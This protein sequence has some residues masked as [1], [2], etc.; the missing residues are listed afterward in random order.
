ML[1]NG[2][3]IFPA[4]LKSIRE[5]HRRVSFETYIYTAGEMAEQ[6]TRA[7]EEA[8]RR[9]VRVNLVIDAV[10]G[11]IPDAHVERLR[12]AGCRLATFNTPS[13]YSLEEIN[14]R[15]HRKI[16]VVDGQLAFTGGVGIDDQWK[17]TPRTRNTG[18]TR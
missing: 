7:F 3:Q 2:D 1:T 10:G 8:A 9:G 16:L 18:G 17:G 6:F 12:A 14:Y 4:M 5:A 13:W 11:T 15:T